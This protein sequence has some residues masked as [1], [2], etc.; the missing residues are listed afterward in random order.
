MHFKTKGKSFDKCWMQV[1]DKEYALSVNVNVFLFL[2]IHLLSQV[3]RKCRPYVDG[4]RK[5]SN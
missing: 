2:T 3:L 5:I 1:F 4:E